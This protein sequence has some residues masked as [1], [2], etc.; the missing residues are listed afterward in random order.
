MLVNII[1]VQQHQHYQKVYVYHN[2]Y[3]LTVVD[4]NSRYLFAFPCRDM[5]TSIIIKKHLELFSLFGM[6]ACIH[7]DC[8]ASLVPL[9]LKEFLTTHGIASSH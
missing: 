3:I 7:S 6:P 4:R 1:N 8:G 9:E 5:T 2:K